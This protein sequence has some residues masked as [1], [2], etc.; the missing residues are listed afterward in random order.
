MAEIPF[1]VGGAPIGN[2]FHP[3]LASA[4]EAMLHAAWA[5]GMREIDTAPYYGHGLSE[6]RIGFHLVMS[7]EQAFAVSTKVGRRLEPCE[8]TVTP[9]HGFA[10]PLPFRP[11]FDYSAFGVQTTFAASLRRLGVNRVEALYLHD[12]GAATHGADHPR[13]F[14]QAANEALPAMRAI[15]REGGARLIGIGV[16]EWQVAAALLD[17]LDLDRVLLAGRYNLLDQSGLAFLDQARARGVE[18]QIA[19]VFASGLLVGGDTVDYVA[20]DVS[21]RSRRDRLAA[22]CARH[23]VPLAA[24]ALAFPLAHPAVSRLVVGWRAPGEVNSAVGWA[25]MSIGAELWEDMRR[26]HLIAGEAPVPA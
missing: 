12:I 10:E 25:Q 8:P 5:A 7:P 23:A 26:E 3:V 22:V 4:A 15:Q 6:A 14:E 1:V 11:V 21:A 9:S 18:V 20:A 19:G 2:L 24:A 13:I 17:R 16:N